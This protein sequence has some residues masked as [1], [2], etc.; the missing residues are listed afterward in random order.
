MGLLKLGPTVINLVNGLLSQRSRAIYT[1]VWQ[2]FKSFLLSLNL[3]P[4]LPLATDIVLAY[5]AHLSS[6]GYAASTIATHVS[7]LGFVHKI[8]NLPNPSENFLINK[9]VSRLLANKQPDTRKPLSA[10]TLQSML[11]GLRFVC[12][13]P[14]DCFLFRCM[15]IT[16]FTAMLRISEITSGN[17]SNHSISYSN[18]QLGNNTVSITLT[19]FKHS[20][21]PVTLILSASNNKLCPVRAMFDYLAIRG[22]KAG[23]LFINADGTAVT[24]TNFIKHLHECLSYCGV[25]TKSISSHSFRIGGATYAALSGY[26]DDQIKKMGRWKSNALATYIRLPSVHVG[27]KPTEGVGGW[28]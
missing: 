7:A 2:C 17:R 26:S 12:K 6:S 9:I 13:S 14:Y 10:E 21:K 18:V 1:Q 22:Q 25:N 15:F 4:A 3:V 20:N 27:P 24:R 23:H 11:D 19:S 8:N 5:I 28:R 16:A